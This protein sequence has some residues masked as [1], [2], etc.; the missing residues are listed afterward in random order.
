MLN[1]LLLHTDARVLQAVANAC[2]HLLQTNIGRSDAGIG[3]LTEIAPAC[4]LFIEY[5]FSPEEKS[6]LDVFKI[7]GPVRS[8]LAKPNFA[9]ELLPLFET[10]E[11]FTHA[12]WIKKFTILILQQFGDEHLSAVASL[13]VFFLT[14]IHIHTLRT[15]KLLIL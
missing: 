5:I 3:R 4:D 13:Q 11:N 8:L 7:R 10:D 2:A 12:V 9:I 14:H 6:H 1:N 15:S